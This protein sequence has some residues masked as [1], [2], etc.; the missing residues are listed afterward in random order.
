MSLEE[1]PEYFADTF[2]IT[3][4]VAQII[5][6]VAVILAIVLPTMYLAKDKHQLPVIIMLFVSIAL[7]VGLTWL[8][9]WMLIV[10]LLIGASG[11]AYLGSNMIGGSG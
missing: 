4:E 3:T 9:F 11:I 10:S 1:I 5:L 2:G 8:P 6:S 7:L